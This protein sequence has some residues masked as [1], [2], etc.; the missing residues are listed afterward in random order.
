MNNERDLIVQEMDLP[1]LAQFQKPLSATASKFV[2]QLLTFSYLC[3][4]MQRHLAILKSELTDIRQ[5]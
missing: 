5:M 4:T 2:D 3:A 1:A